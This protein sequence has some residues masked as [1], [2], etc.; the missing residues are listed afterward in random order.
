MFVSAGHSHLW[1]LCALRIPR[2]FRCS[3]HWG[4]LL[5]LCCRAPWT[6]K[7]P[8]HLSEVLDLN[9]VFSQHKRAKPSAFFALRC[10]NLWVIPLCPWKDISHR[11]AGSQSSSSRVSSRQDTRSV[12]WWAEHTTG[13]RKTAFGNYSQDNFLFVQWLFNVKCIKSLGAKC[14]NIWS[15]DV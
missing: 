2:S 4:R 15:E 13:R 14:A 11:W 12:A 10:P 5:C 3:C 9:V 1:D 7:A 6:P 8:A